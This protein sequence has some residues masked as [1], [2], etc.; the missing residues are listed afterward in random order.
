[1]MFSLTDFHGENPL[2]DQIGMYLLYL[3]IF[4]VI[5]NSIKTMWGGIVYYWVRIKRC[6]V[7]RARK[8][9]KVVEE[10]NEVKI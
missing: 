9:A 4:T 10:E 3:V 7:K 6:R 5:V 2:R 8:E 1:M